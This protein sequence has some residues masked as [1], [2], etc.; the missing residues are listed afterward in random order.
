MNSS[1]HQTRDSTG[2]KS[3]VLLDCYLVGD[4][5]VKSPQLMINGHHGHNCFMDQPFQGHASW[6]RFR[7]IG[8]HS[9]YHIRHDCQSR[10]PADV[11]TTHRNHNEQCLT[12]L[13][14]NYSS[15]GSHASPSSPFWL[16]SLLPVPQALLAL[17]APG[18]RAR[19]RSKWR[20]GSCCELR[21]RSSASPKAPKGDRHSTHMTKSQYGNN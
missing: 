3:L 8:G 21:R 4:F 7:T 1:T 9:F 19:S 20:S 12:I 15:A 14:Q 11:T 13:N 18:V 16:P 5:V 10:S 6:V 2:K 17:L